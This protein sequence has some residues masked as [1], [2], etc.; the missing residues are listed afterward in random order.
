MPQVQHRAQ[1]GHPGP[2]Q[3]SSPWHGTEAGGAGP[4]SESHQEGLEL[5]I[6]VMGGTEAPPTCIPD[7]PG[8]RLV[9]KVTGLP[10]EVSGRLRG[11]DVRQPER[12][13]E[14]PAGCFR[15]RGVGIRIHSSQVMVDVDSNGVRAGTVIFPVTEHDA[16]AEQGH[17]VRPATEGNPEPGS[18][19]ESAFPGQSTGDLQHERVSTCRQRQMLLFYPCRNDLRW[20]E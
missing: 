14:S 20:R 17:G 8:Q 2:G 16:C 1:E 5:V 19:L 18:V 10:G 7:F 11:M 4:P 13:I 12:D 15:D 6:G 3:G 9:A